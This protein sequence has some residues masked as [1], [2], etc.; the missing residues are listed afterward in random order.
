M[1]ERLREIR[2]ALNLSQDEF[3]TRLGITKSSISGH[4]TGRRNMSEQTI[5][6]ICREF[7]VNEEWLRTGEG[8]MFLA[9]PQEDEFIRAAAEISKDGDPVLMQA[10]IDYWKLDKDSKE[11]LK[12][13]LVNMVDTM[14]NKK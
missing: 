12:K 7:D 14:K 9:R 13:F 8:E 11:L 6:S 1:N 5:T 3:A 2:L 4:E 10:I